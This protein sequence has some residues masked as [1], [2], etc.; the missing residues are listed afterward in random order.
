MKIT[1]KILAPVAIAAFAFLAVAPKANADTAAT[2]NIS[3]YTSVTST[4]TV[5]VTPTLAE[6]QSTSKAV[7][8]AITLNVTTNNSTGCHVAVS[9]LT[10]ADGRTSAISPADIQLQSATVGT[11]TAFASYAGLTT[12]PATLWNTAASAVN[13][14]AVTVDVK[15]ASLDLYKAVA[16]GTKAYINTIVFTAT[17]N[18]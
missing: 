10:A 9:A 13:G 15:F 6:I 7:P 16:G 1:S 2:L 11:N 14:T 3:N 12:T 4:P 17:A 5:S 18:P 8:G